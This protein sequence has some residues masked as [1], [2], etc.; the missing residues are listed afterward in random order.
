MFADKLIQRPTSGDDN[1]LGGFFIT[2]NGRSHQLPPIYF[3]YTYSLSSV[4]NP[5]LV[6]T[7]FY[8]SLFPV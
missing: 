1:F 4:V 7:L 3:Y 2:K 5:S 6:L 8:F